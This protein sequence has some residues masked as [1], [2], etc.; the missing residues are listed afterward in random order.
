ML[1][2]DA[3]YILRWFLNDIEEQ[4]S[5]VDTLLKTADSES[6]FIDRVTIAEITYVLRAKNYDHHQIYRVFEEIYYYPSVQSPT[7][8]DG[9]AQELY[10]DTTLDF[11]DCV[12]I[13]H[14]KVNKYSVGTFDKAINKLIEKP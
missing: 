11:E 14:Q 12:L 5:A 2:I 10:R 13:A 7:S 8:L 6:I 4:A 1:V 3:N 9:T